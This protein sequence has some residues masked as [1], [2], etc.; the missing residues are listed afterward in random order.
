M[1]GAAPYDFLAEPEPVTA[2]DTAFDQ[3]ITLAEFLAAAD[4]RFEALDVKGNGHIALADLPKTAVQSPPRPG[5]ARRR[6]TT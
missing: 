2:A 3:R 5:Q 4:R 6:P 1:T